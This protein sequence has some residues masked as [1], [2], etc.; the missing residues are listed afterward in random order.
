M[1][2]RAISAILSTMLAAS[3]LA[4][5]G[6]SS[7]GTTAGSES[8]TTDSAAT[9]STAAEEEVVSDTAGDPNG[10]HLD[11]WTF[12]E[13]H[14][15]FYR[16][17][18]EQW[19]KENPDKTI[20]LTTITYPYSD[21]HNK[22]LM[23]FQAGTGAPDICDV[24]V[25]Q[26][27]NVVAYEENALQPLNDVI[28][29]Y[30]AT[31]VKSRLE[32]YQGADGNYYG[33]PF[34][35]GATLMYYNLAELESV[36]ITQADVDAVKTW[37]DYEALGKKYCEA[38]G[39]DGTHF[40]TSVDTGGCDIIWVAMAEYGEDWTGG[41]EG[42]ANVQLESVKKMLEYEK[43]WQEEGIAQVTKGGQIDTEDGFQSILS[44]EVVAFPKAAWY[45]SR[46][47]NYM[48]EEEGNWYLAPCPVFEEGQKN[49]VG[50]GGTGT[51]VTKQGQNAEL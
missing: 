11:L 19:N 31:V 8:G 51:V 6:G 15:T 48:E 23:S 40:W 13:L 3:L 2:K 12:V 7:A 49:S 18:V 39:N 32:T 45:M 30:E 16:D 20:E 36:G 44:K 27:P 46:F 10:T 38:R 26:F 35:V 5:C 9:E 22:L 33:V 50:I 47:L 29:P 1:K 37:D 21:M 4:G 42:P 34:H 24:E 17:M 14:G 25:G 43:R 41:F 28:A